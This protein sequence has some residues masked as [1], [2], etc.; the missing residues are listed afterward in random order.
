MANENVRT[1]MTNRNFGFQMPDRM[2]RITHAPITLTDASTSMNDSPPRYLYTSRVVRPIGLEIIRS[3]VPL[4]SM[5]GM[6]NEV[7]MIPNRMATAAPNP[8]IRLSSTHQT[9]TPSGVYP[10]TAFI[11]NAPNSGW[12]SCGQLRGSL[13]AV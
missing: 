2:P 13:G 8:L 11:E 7:T 1:G 9:I 3:T 4:R 10:I 5:F 12:T 6:K